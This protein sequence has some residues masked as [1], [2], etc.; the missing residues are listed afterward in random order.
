[1]GRWLFFMIIIC[2]LSGV[3]DRDWRGEELERM[4]DVSLVSGT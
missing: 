4:V 1:M 3:L 2:R